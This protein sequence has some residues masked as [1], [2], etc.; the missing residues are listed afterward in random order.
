MLNYPDSFVGIQIH[1]GDA[2]VSDWSAQRANFYRLLYTPTSWFDG[3]IENV[4]GSSQTYNEYNAHRA[5]RAAVPTDI[6]IELSGVET[7][8][9]TYDI[10][11]T[12]SMDPD[13]TSR[14]VKVHFVQVLD[15]YP[16]S[17]DNRYRNCVMQHQD[18]GTHALT[19]GGS[20]DIT[21][22]IALS[23]ASWTYKED[24]QMIVFV[25][26]PLNPG[27]KEVYNAAVMSWPFTAP[28]VVGDVDGD[29]DVDLTDLSE[30]LACYGTCVGD[31]D[32]NE[33]AD[34]IDDDCINL[35]D[36]S[37]LLSNYGYGT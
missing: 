5:T 35:S 21:V 9:Q 29:G 27:P 1:V 24:V 18:G 36:L 22:P 32:Y 14:D 37:A 26:E 34:F 16:Y 33:D 13:G 2:Y 11:A 10:T 3:I 25:R 17:S 12:I 6:S 19:A 28:D 7:A 8:A 31:P 23:G 4:G 20:L 30:L 15:Y